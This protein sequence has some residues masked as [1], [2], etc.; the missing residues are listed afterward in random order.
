MVKTSCLNVSTGFFTCCT[1][2]AVVEVQS[3]RF[4][5][6]NCCGMDY[7]QSCDIKKTKT[8]AF[9]LKILNGTFNCLR[10]PQENTSQVFLCCFLFTGVNTYCCCLGCMLAQATSC[11]RAM[12][13]LIDVS[14][15]EILSGHLKWG[16]L[17]TSQL[18]ERWE[19]LVGCMR[20]L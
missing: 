17:P 11:C 5:I 20:W 9:Q 4:F 10:H 18:S 3:N 14:V 16:I 1:L 13:S 8:P 7:C 15:Q 6:P 12:L 19:F 2:M